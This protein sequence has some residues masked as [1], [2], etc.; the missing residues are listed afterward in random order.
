MS[1]RKFEILCPSEP[2]VKERPTN[3]SLFYVSRSNPNFSSN[4]G[5]NYFHGPTISVF[6]HPEE[7]P[8]DSSEVFRINE[9]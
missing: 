2:T 7:F 1:E 3:Y 9:S 6:Q 8:I 4:T 5:V